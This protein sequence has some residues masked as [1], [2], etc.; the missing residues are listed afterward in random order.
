[1]QGIDSL[2]DGKLPGIDSL[3]NGKLPGID[4]LADGKLPGID[5]LANFEL[6]RLI[7]YNSDK[8]SCGSRSGSGS[9]ESISFSWIR[10]RIN[11]WLD[12]ESGSVSN[13]TDSDTT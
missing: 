9:V 12:L 1:M 7:G 5:S 6:E 4:S 13:D 3:A 8:Q 10:I 11:N 2:A